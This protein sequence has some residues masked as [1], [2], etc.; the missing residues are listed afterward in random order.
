MRLRKS[1]LQAPEQSLS[2]PR[3]NVV[4]DGDITLVDGVPFTDAMLTLF[5]KSDTK[6]E[7]TTFSKED[8]LAMRV[9][10]S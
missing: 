6:R 8:F 7:K 2:E 1:R 10:I 5:S 3:V 9:K 4:Q